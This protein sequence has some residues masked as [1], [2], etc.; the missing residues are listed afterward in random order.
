MFPFAFRFCGSCVRTKARV[1]QEKPTAFEPLPDKDSDSKVLY[2]M[3]CFK[4]LQFKVG[5]SVYMPPDTFN[6]R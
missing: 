6:F 1:E 2:A 4:G 3:A 5:D